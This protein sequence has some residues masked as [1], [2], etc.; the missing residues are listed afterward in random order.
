[1]ALANTESESLADQIEQQAAASFPC[2]PGVATSVPLDK[3]AGRYQH[4]ACGEAQVLLL[5]NKLE[6]RLAEGC[7][8]DTELTHVGNDVFECRL[9]RPEARDFMPTAWRGRFEVKDGKVLWLEDINARYE[10]VSSS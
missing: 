3:M 4:K 2:T 1:V 8:W 7:L 6:M 10:R 9:L 5:K